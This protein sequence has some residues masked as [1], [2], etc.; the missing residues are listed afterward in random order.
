ME[1]EGS[2]PHSQAPAHNRG[3]PTV[4][5]SEIFV[6]DCMCNTQ[7]FFVIEPTQ[8]GWHTSKLKKKITV[9][10]S[11]QVKISSNHVPPEAVS[12]PRRAVYFYG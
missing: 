7:K 10:S 2:S 12:C 5:L 6:L 3:I 8:R 9:V 1:P 4:L 11:S